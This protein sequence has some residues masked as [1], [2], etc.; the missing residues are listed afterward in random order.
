MVAGSSRANPSIATEGPLVPAPPGTVSI[1]Q[2]RYR[3]APLSPRPTVGP[4]HGDGVSRTERRRSRP[5]TPAAL[6]PPKMKRPRLAIALLC[7]AGVA[8][9][10]GHSGAGGLAGTGTVL[11]GSPSLAIPPSRGSSLPGSSPSFPPLQTTTGHV[12]LAER[13]NGRSIVVPAGTRI[14]VDLSGS[15]LVPGQ[16]VYRWSVPKSTDTAVLVPVASNQAPDGGTS[17]TFLASAR[18]S[19]TISAVDSCPKACMA[20]AVLWSVVVNVTG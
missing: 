13:D 6:E 5:E 15:G 17:A 19:A 7:L 3:P 14:K 4:S 16:P 9:A 18:G 11:A 8:G 1:L 2:D 12:A 10:C 20:P